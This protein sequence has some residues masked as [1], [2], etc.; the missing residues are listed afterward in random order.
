MTAR[1]TR[2]WVGVLV[3][4]LLAV[5][6]GVVT[7]QPTVVLGALVGVAYLTYPHLVQEPTPAVSLRRSLDRSTAP[8]GERIRVD[9]TVRNDGD[10]ALSDLRVVDGVPS[11]V[12][13]V[14]G[15][16]RLA[17]ALAPDESTRFSYWI[18]S[19]DGTHRFDPA[20]VAVRDRAGAHE[21]VT[22]AGAETRLVG[23]VAARDDVATD[24]LAL[25]SGRGPT[26]DGD[27]QSFTRVR[28]YRRG[29]PPSR[30]DWR[31]LARTGDLTTVEYAERHAESVLLAVDARPS[32]VRAASTGDGRHAVG[33][34]AAAAEAVCRS[35]CR[36]GGRVGLVVLG[37]TD[38]AASVERGSRHRDRVL[39]LLTDHPAL[40]TPADNDE[41]G[42]GALDRRVA[43][44]ASGTHVVCLSPLFDDALV[45]TLRALVA[46]GRAVSLVSPDVVAD[47]PLGARVVGLERAERLR[48]LRAV[49]VHVLDWS[50]GTPLDA[51]LPVVV[52]R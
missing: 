33:H 35:V 21:V 5:A 40:R 48:T 45:T 13:V 23:G 15:S 51:S 30:I 50:P 7:R 12:P 17:T 36:R 6:V 18:R 41:A 20:T 42:L 25:G 24:S 26:S 34:A 49:G 19:V 37:D 31:R 39:D 2:R 16:A 52:G 27:G 10:D 44:A 14:D 32:A 3:V 46:R 9:V 1:P 43:G 38:C 11:A 8:A 22:T 4:P 47:G 29:D 28:A